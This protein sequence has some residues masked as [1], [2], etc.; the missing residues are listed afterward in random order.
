MFSIFI[1]EDKNE[2]EK[3]TEELLT[4]QKIFE[5]KENE[6]TKKEEQQKENLKT[7]QN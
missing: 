3:T 2:K 5:A 7:L 4:A 1:S 6:W